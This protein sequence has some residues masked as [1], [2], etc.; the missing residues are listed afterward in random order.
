MGRSA[1]RSGTVVLSGLAFP[2]AL[3][4]RAGRLVFS[5]IF[6]RSV[7]MLATDGSRSCLV[8]TD[9]SPSGL[10]WRPD[11]TLLI[12]GMRQRRLLA[13]GDDGIAATVADLSAVTAG[14]CNDMVVDGQGRAYVGHFGYDY[15]AGEQR[16][17]ST[18][19]AIDPDGTV[20]TVAEGLQFPNGM[21]LTPDGS[22]L[23]VAE[24][25][26][27]RITAFA[28]RAGGSLGARS[29][30]A[31]FPDARPDGISIDA[32]GAVWLASPA[33]GQVLRVDSGG[34]VLDRIDVDGGPTCC[35]L[36]GPRLTTLFVSCGPEH[37]EAAALR[38]RAGRI[39]AFEVDVPAA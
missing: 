20:R 37:D 1:Q 19:V 9:D 29:T 34:A 10:G 21:V 38:K 31:E 15:T 2:E 33:T 39:L 36:G 25:H 12:V 4:W 11:G 26:A 22:T 3:R 13:L 5:D 35:A 30:F 14:L 17:P 23:L 7:S 8:R 6:D 24:T 28:V 16:R 18:L 32:S 27:H